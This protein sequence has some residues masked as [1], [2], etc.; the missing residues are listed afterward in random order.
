MADRGI[1]CNSEIKPNKT[2][3]KRKTR[4]IIMGP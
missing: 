3:Y 4:K 2:C 1:F